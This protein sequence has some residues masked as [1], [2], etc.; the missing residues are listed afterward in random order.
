M[1]EFDG[2]RSDSP[3]CDSAETKEKGLAIS[4]TPNREI[5]AAICSILVNGS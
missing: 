2:A 1:V 4:T 5:Y 3:E